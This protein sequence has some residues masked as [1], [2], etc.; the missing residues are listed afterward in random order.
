MIDKLLIANRGEI[1]AR[2][3]R[4][5]KRLGL[6]TV[7]VH[8]EADT[9]AL[10]VRQ[11]DE[12]FHIGPASARDSYLKIEQVLLAARSTGA[13]A[14]HPG[15]GF[16]SENASFAES[17]R[18]AGLIFVGPPT[19]AIAAMGSKVAARES[20]RA[21]D[22]PLLPG[23]GALA[24]VEAAVRAAD[25]LGYPV[26]I[27][28]S[29]GG[30]GI[31]MQAAQNERELRQRFSSVAEGAARFFSDATV[32]LE[33]MLIAP[34]H[35]EIQIAGDSKGNMVHL[36]E[37]ECSI[38]RRHQKVLEETPS[39]A[40]SPELRQRMT[41]AALRLAAHV[42]YSSLGTVEF[43]VAGN[44]FYFLE[45]NTRL[46][47]EHTVTEMV[48]GLDL[49]EWQIRIALGE[50]L[51]ALQSAIAFSGH[52]FQCRISAENPDKGFLPSPGQI[53]D[54]VLPHGPGVRNDA[55]VELGDYVT[56]Y[57][58]PMIA[59]LVVHGASRNAAIERL[60]EA[61]GAY[62]IEGITT[63]LPLHQRIVHDAAFL[64]GDLSTAFLRDRFALKI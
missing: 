18:Q 47:V 14:V 31:G 63:N 46:Q 64:K 39:P 58:D 60:K 35:I 17:C 61:L 45:M 25:E 36:G 30:G 37:R 55:G 22:V 33:K 26:L 56:P 62:R 50:E 32:Y 27:K 40:V 52:A 20:A 16:L 8:S 41:Q 54:F 48:T 38:Q 24:D 12:A 21:A 9:R 53:T 29:A 7:A 49:V 23:T 51:P 6:G 5:A 4:T 28:A 2:I 34:R 44:D 15:Y 10:H 19:A 13:N 57:Y 42:N 1:A 3:M 59:K 43:L 11:A